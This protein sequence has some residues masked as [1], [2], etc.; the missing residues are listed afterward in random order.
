MLTMYLVTM[1][2]RSIAPIAPNPPVPLVPS[3]PLVPSVLA[4]SAASATPFPPAPPGLLTRAA[5]SKAHAQMAEVSSFSPFA[6][7]PQSSTASHVAS[8]KRCRGP[9]VESSSD[10]ISDASDEDT[11]KKMEMPPGVSVPQVNVQMASPPR[12]EEVNLPVVTG[13]VCFYLDCDRL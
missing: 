6:L 3:A 1:T 4:A 2:D 5:K 13:N 7:P 8:G 12:I 10:E 11:P 9:A